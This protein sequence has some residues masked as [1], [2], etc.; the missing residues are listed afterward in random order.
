[1]EHVI[2]NAFNNAIKCALKSTLHDE[3]DHLVY[4]NE[5]GSYG[6]IRCE[7]GKLVAPGDNVKILGWTEFSVERG[8]PKAIYLEFERPLTVKDL[9][10]Y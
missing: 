7:R 6:F 4:L 5:D 1:M 8:I 2:N 10:I 9:G 3:S